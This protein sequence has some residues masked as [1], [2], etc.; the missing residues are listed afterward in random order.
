[1]MNNNNRRFKQMIKLMDITR[2]HYS[3]SEGEN[4]AGAIIYCKAYKVLF[5]WNNLGSI[6]LEK[7]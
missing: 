2:K 7:L 5:P 3:R 1:M 4:A 6:F